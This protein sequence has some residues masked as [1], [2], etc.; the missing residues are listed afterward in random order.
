[1]KGHRLPPCWIEGW[2][3]LPKA[4][5]NK[6]YKDLRREGLEK[7]RAF[8]T[9][10]SERQGFSP[11]D[12]TQHTRRAWFAWTFSVG[13]PL[14]WCQEL[15]SRIS[16]QFYTQSMRLW[17]R[18]VLSDM[19]APMDRREWARDALPL[20]DDLYRE[21]VSWYNRDRKVYR[22]DAIPQ[23][24]PVATVARV[25]E[26]IE[27]SLGHPRYPWDRFLLRAAWCTGM[28]T[29]HLVNVTPQDVRL[30]LERWDAG[31]NPCLG[32]HV[33]PHGK[34]G[35]VRPGRKRLYPAYWCLPQ[36]RAALEEAPVEWRDFA[37]LIHP[38]PQKKNVRAAHST[39]KAIRLITD[40]LVEV[41]SPIV[42]ADTRDPRVGDYRVLYP[43]ILTTAQARLLRELGDWA[44][45]SQ[46]R[47]W[48]PGFL[49]KQP[50][51]REAISG[52]GP[53]DI[54]YR[55]TFNREAPR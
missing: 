39:T 46:L 21:E 6:T 14:E 19:S 5:R 43:L 35:R 23:P 54:W 1:M 2:D 11:H 9:W 7:F 49:Q 47:D 33:R 32:V 15:P 17:C 18:W 36:L 3:K 26:A 27:D 10:L 22:N 37:D 24:L 30:L 34:G 50:W 20:L 48:S 45:A 55:G 41:A 29:R 16:R 12:T 38:R 40:R 31:G 51:A 42:A 25:E 8:R 44:T 52:V 28:R 4:T 53:D 13:R